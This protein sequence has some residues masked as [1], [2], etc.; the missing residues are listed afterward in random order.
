MASQSINFRPT[1][2]IKHIP[3]SLDKKTALG[4]LLIL[5]TFSLVG[6]LYLGQASLITSSTLQIERLQQEI[7]LVNQQNA[8]LALEIAEIESL[9]RIEER[10]RALGFAPTDPANIRYLPVDHY[11]SLSAATALPDFQQPPPVEQTW[12]IWLDNLMAWI[13]GQP[14]SKE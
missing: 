12:Q 1:A 7:K 5:A 13:V 9:S 4:L 6:W 11:P 10:A 14:T 3:W 2:V 8:E